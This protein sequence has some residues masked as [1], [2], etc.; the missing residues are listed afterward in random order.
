MA[1][2]LWAPMAI[3]M[4]LTMK[5]MFMNRKLNVVLYAAF[6][7]VFVLSFWGIRGQLLVG[8]REFLRSMI[9]HHSGAVLMCNRAQVRDPEIKQLCGNIIRS[10]TQEIDQMKG[11]LR[12]L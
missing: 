10:Q 3:V 4:M 5:S 6:A 9:P 1:L 7:A 12:R 2:V 8:D 11:I